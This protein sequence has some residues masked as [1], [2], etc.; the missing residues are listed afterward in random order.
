MEEELANLNLINEEEDAFHEEATV[1]D[2]NY[3][4]SLVGRCLTNSVV[5]F[6]SLRNTM[7]DLW[8]PIGGI[9]I[10]DLREKRFL[11]PFFHDVDVQGVLSGTL[12]FFN[13]HLLILHKIQ[14]GEEPL[15]VSL[16]LSEFWVQ[17]HDLALGLMTETMAK[18]F[19]DFLGQF[20]EYDT[21]F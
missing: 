14:M 5:Y 19:G 16:Y 6:P 12:W 20:L 8:H 11:C 15:L 9:C 18:Q 7:A 21:S 4:F 10:L 17:I 13:N 2:Q 1:V 3:Q